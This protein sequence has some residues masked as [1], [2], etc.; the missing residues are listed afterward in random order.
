VVT[1]PHVERLVQSLVRWRLVFLTLAIVVPAGCYGMFERQARRLDALGDHGAPAVATV[2]AVDP[3]GTV[4]YAYAVSGAR[5]TWNVGPEEALPAVG[6]AFPIVYLPEDPALSRPGIDRS[7]ATREAAS[8][9]SVAW[10]VE[11]GAFAFFAFNLIL[12]DVRLRRLRKTGLTELSDPQ[13]YRTRLVLT[14]AMLVPILLLVFGWNL[15]D[16]LRRGEPVWPVVLGLV[17]T[18]AVIGGAGFYVLREGRAQ[19]TDR[20]A[21]VLRWALPLAAVIA[22]LRLAAWL[23]VRK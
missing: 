13:A 17:I 23:I 21:R 11:A 12:C 9:R 19:A 15:G 2:A 8:N 5:Y 3:G 16:A 6:K 1:T 18:L 14:G 22:V 10:K 20:S 7:R 4:D